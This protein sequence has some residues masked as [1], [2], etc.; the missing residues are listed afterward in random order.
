MGEC[1]FW[2]RPT[3]VVPEKRPLKG[4]VCVRVRVRVRMRVCVCAVA[5][6]CGRNYVTHL[7]VCFISFSFFLLF[8]SS[9]QQSQAVTTN[10]E[11]DRKATKH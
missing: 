11:L 5:R 1:F 6:I 8:C 7:C 4:C 10:T 2:Y 9:N 3:L